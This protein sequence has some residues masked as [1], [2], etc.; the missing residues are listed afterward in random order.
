MADDFERN[1]GL[2]ERERAL[3]QPQENK[4]GHALPWPDETNPTA[5]GDRFAH[6][7]TPE[8]GTLGRSFE[9]TEDASG[10]RER[11]ELG[12]EFSNPSYADDRRLGDSFADPNA[13]DDARLGNSFTEAESSAKKHRRPVKE[14]VHP[15]ANRKPLWIGL[16]VFALIFLVVVLVGWLPRHSRSKEIQGRAKRESNAKPVVEVETVKTA[17]AQPGLVVPGTTLPLTEAYVYARANGYLKRRLADIGDHVRKNQLLA[18]IDAPD[19]DQQVDQ[20][21]QQLRQAQQQLEQQK[22]QLALN[23]VTVGRYR[24]LVAKGVFSRQDGDTQEANYASQV[25]N[26]T[27]AQRNVEAYAANL[28]R[29]EAL[30]SYEYVRSPFDGIVTQ[31]NVDVGALISAQGSSGGAQTMPAPQ[32]QNS[33]SGGSQQA[34]Q[35][36][37]AG[38]SGSTNT[39]ATSAQSPG[40]GGPLFGIAQV[41]RLRVLVSVPEGYVSSIH[42]GAHAQLAFQEYAGAS[43]TGDITRTANSVDPNTRT[44]LT[45]IQVDNR[46]ERLVPGM[47]TVATFPVANASA[48]GPIMIDGDAVAVRHDQSMVAVVSGG[49]VRYTPIVIGRD[50]GDQ[51]E[52]VSGLKPG[53]MIVTD[54]TDDVVDGAAV[55]THM[56][57]A[58]SQPAGAGGTQNTPPGGSTRYGNPAITDQNLQ[59]KQSQQNANQPKGKAGVQEEKRTQ[60]ESHQ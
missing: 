32:G 58:E 59:G 12:R 48:S 55:E 20:A 19:L 5:L 9:R 41:Y 40:Q 27:A 15:P 13:T 60:S 22:S 24:V 38:S 45:E 26:V 14:V 43:L 42:P 53:D 36:N 44:M 25:A 57:K 4:A 35:S 21:R 31:R 2:N 28:R 51:I 23:T 34:G 50:F 30:Q 37:N 11:Q 39:A 1:R 8:Q 33:V 6:G 7:P 16:A 18:V 47:Y 52:V 49:K 54:V 10:R 29:N 46:N 56:A 3:P 17:K